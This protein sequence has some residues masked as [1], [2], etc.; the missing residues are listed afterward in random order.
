M[1][2][3]VNFWEYGEENKYDFNVVIVFLFIVRLFIGIVF[4]KLIELELGIGVLF[5]DD[6]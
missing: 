6:M 2:I 3:S 1:E 5:L 4:N